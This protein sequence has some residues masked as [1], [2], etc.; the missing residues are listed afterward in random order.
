MEAQS[1]VIGAHRR[2][3]GIDETRTARWQ[4]CEMRCVTNH[5]PPLCPILSCPS[6]PAPS[7]R[8]SAYSGRQ[9]THDNACDRQPSSHWP[10][11]RMAHCRWTLS[12]AR[13]RLGSSGPTANST[14]NQS[15][16]MESVNLAPGRGVPGRGVGGSCDEVQ[17]TTPKEM[18]CAFETYRQ[19]C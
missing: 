17:L 19:F 11:A 9:F 15:D 14:V 5:A 18:L 3:D 12:I 16:N 13:H 6:L 2:S 7:C 10:M 1:S 4:E 8:L